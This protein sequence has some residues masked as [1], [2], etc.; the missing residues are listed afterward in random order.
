MIEHGGLDGPLNRGPPG[1][2]FR[3]LLPGRLADE[4][5]N[6]TDRPTPLSLAFDSCQTLRLQNMHQG[7]T[8]RLVGQSNG[9]HEWRGL[10]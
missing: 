4:L 6:I 3:L 1:V 7:P 8:C 9:I 10:T 5:V 2:L